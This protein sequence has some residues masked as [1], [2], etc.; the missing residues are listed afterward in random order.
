MKRIILSLLT[1]GIVAVVATGATTALLSDEE[2]SSGN[3]F[4]AG[5]VDLGVDNHSYYNGNECS[6]VDDDIW[7]W[8]GNAEYPE[9]G[10]PCETSWIVDYDIEHNE[11]GETEVRRFFA[12]IKAATTT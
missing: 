4:T 5:A 1:L 9:P 3:T 10:T 11:Q 2:I 12:F 6:E 7:Q 8:V